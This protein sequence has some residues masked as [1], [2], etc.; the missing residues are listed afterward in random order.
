MTRVVEFYVEYDG[1]QFD[2]DALWAA[3]TVRKTQ[4]D[5]YSFGDGVG[6]TAG[7]T[8]YARTQHEVLA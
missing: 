6:I 7:P 1:R 8:L 3:L 4:P 2:N 5:S